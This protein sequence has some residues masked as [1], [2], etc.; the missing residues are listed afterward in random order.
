MEEDQNGP[1][2]IRVRKWMK[3]VYESTDVKSAKYIGLD[4]KEISIDSLSTDEKLDKIISLI[5]Y[6]PNVGKKLLPLFTELESPK[7]D[8]QY[9][10]YKTNITFN[11]PLASNIFSFKKLSY[12]L[13]II[14]ELI[15]FLTI[16]ALA[17]GLLS[18]ILKR[19]NNG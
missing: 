14:P 5:T 15:I 11:L 7:K 18:E 4:P 12:S 3:L 10:L 2:S 6:R 16:M 19:E 8:G 13:Y 1:D 17:G 9:V